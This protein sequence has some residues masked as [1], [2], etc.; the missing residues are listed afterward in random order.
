MTKCVLR[1]LGPALLL[2]STWSAAA[3]AETCMGVD[4][5]NTFMSGAGAATTTVRLEFDVTGV[6]PSDF[7][8]SKGCLAEFLDSTCAL[9]AA[10]NLKVYGPYDPPNAS[11]PT[12]TLKFEFG[13]MCC[14]VLP[15]QTEGWAD[16]GTSATVFVDGS[17]KCSVKLTL[18]PAHIAYSL[19]CAGTLFEAVGDNVDKVA[20]T[21]L[22]V[23]SRNDGGWAM[24]NAMATSVKVCFEP[25]V[26]VPGAL[27]MNIPVLEDVTT[28]ASAG[29]AVYPGIEELGLEANDSEVYLKFDLGA[30]PGEVKKARIFL[31]ESDIASADGDGGDAYVVPDP[32][33]S[34]NTLTWAKRPATSGASLARVSPVAAFTWY[35]WDV[36]A[37]VEKPAVYAFALKPEASDLNGAHFF[38]KEGTATFRPYMLIEYVVVDADGD[39]H[40]DGP[41]CNDADPAVF[42]GA[43]EVCNGIDD[44]CN[45]V[46]D[47]GCVGGA[48]GAGGGANGG[49]AGIG[50][51]NTGPGA[52]GVG[53]GTGGASAD[54]SG[55]GRGVADDSGGAVKSGCACDVPRRS[56]S[57]SDAM[58]LL[59]ALAGASAFVARGA[60]S[61]KS[62]AAASNEPD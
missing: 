55:N 52:G 49:G 38:S 39:G 41:D 18:D 43:V 59:L 9:G 57:A 14:P 25:P 6:N 23:L 4:D 24:P 19:D 37:A 5:F 22:A 26:V 53:T 11:H 31:H 20:V 56:G 12:G 13:N 33:W 7:A 29:G 60:R 47:D 44:D 1:I 61:R 17:E 42:P 28:S 51:G 45:G 21:Q 40:P 32:S 50:G 36:S 62:A 15:C 48:G 30:V 2:S 46:I 16:P 3:R 10:A 35:S 8:G 27:T 34:E 58:G 54:P